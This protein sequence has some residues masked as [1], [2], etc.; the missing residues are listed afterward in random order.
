MKR[1][2]PV[3]L[4]LTLMVAAAGTAR[5]VDVKVSGYWDFAFG[6]VTNSNFRESV[7][8]RKNAASADTFEARQRIRVQTNFIASEYLQAVIMIEIGDIDWGRNRGNSNGAGRGAGGALDTD[9]VNIETK[10]AYLEWLIPNTQ[11]GVTMGL[12]GVTFP[13]A[14]HMGCNPVFMADVAGVVVSTPV[15]D[16]LSATAFWGRPFDAYNNDA[17]AGF[18]DH[19]FSDE[20]DV[21][22]LLLPMNFN[23]FGA[24]TPYAMYGFMGGNSGYID[25]IYGAGSTNRNSSPDASFRS[26]WLGANLSFTMLDPLAFNLDVIYGRSNNA[27]I[28]GWRDPA[29]GNGYAQGP[30]WQYY[31]HSQINGGS[32]STS[33]WYIGGTLDYKLDFMTPG[34]FAWWSSGDKAGAENSGRL[35]RLPV[36]GTDGSFGPT[37]F[38]SHNFIYIANAQNKGTV[39]STGMG[40]W[41]VGVQAAD[42]SFFEDLTHTIR[43]TYYSGTNDSEIVKR[44]GGSPLMPYTDKFYLTDKDHLI[45]VNFDS[46]YKI[47]ENLLCIVQ[48]GYIRLEADKDTWA[49]GNN[50]LNHGGKEGENSVKAQVAFRYSF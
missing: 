48:L 13:F 9:G 12:Q 5:A 44:T 19:S 25:Y 6:W 7:A 11:V 20:T 4:A 36:L 50:A 24:I 17:E 49:G 22:A 37:S 42:I 3:I 15:T 34:I 8:N 29:T 33:G 28:S 43:V 14:P 16:W 27:D 18:G 30:G 31:A 23:G 1:I 38:G 35:G 32:V 41:G 39:M 47:Y 2:A 26:W 45:E 10:R 46:Y 40:T 21:F